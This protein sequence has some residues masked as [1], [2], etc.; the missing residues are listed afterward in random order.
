MSER[1]IRH[2]K[3][4]REYIPTGLA[5]SDTCR[6]V[7]LT[8]DQIEVL[9]NLVN[10]A[11]DRRNWNDETIDSERYYMPSD[12]DWDDIEA[13]VDDLEDK[14]MSDCDFVT[15][16]DA[17]D[18]M[19][20]D[21]QLLVQA[22][23][24]AIVP[25][26]A[27][28]HSATQSADLQQWMSN[29]GVILS[30]VGKQGHLGVGNAAVAATALHVGRYFTDNG[31]IYTGIAAKPYKTVAGNLSFWGLDCAPV[32]SAVTGTQTTVYG[33][34]GRIRLTGA[35][36]ITDAYAHYVRI[37]NE[38]AGTITSA[39]GLYAGPHINSG[40]G[41]IEN[42]YGLVVANQTAGSILN[43][44]IYTGTGD[45]RLGGDTR[46]V[47]KF[48][49]NNKNPISPQAVGADCTDLSTAV[50]LVNQLRAALIAVGI[51]V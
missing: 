11:H 10:Y 13:L 51:A 14:L 33:T 20:I 6:L 37:D 43:Y 47:G 34:S 5:G 12:D 8:D 48:G 31:A 32:I 23:A 24:D 15:L 3:Y 9:S 18:K 17:N 42:A 38:S 44:A 40:G 30:S 2:F 49:C 35:A 36:T 29:L 7:I 22:H 4:G 39:Y 26:T 41:I 21:G 46:V 50:A 19:T 16:D 1:E 27:K 25:I 28:G 45:V